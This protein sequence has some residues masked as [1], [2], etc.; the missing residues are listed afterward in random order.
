[1]QILRVNAIVPCDSLPTHEPNLMKVMSV[2][3]S[4]CGESSTNT[5]FRL[6]NFPNGFIFWANDPEVIVVALPFIVCGVCL[7]AAGKFYCASD[8][9]CLG[10]CQFQLEP[11]PLLGEETHHE[12]DST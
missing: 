5:K 8:K 11:L 7:R 2:K 6:N 10:T 12:N 9:G 3:C 1:M 4:D